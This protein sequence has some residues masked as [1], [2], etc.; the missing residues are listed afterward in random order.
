MFESGSLLHD[1]PAR[2]GWTRS[3]V[4]LN[5]SILADCGGRRGTGHSQLSDGATTYS[6]ME[7]SGDDGR[8][9]QAGAEVADRRRAG[10]A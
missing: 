4:D 2:G 9:H 7:T 10:S 6:E 1:P 3:I 5:V 8:P